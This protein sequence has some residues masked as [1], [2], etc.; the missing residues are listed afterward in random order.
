MYLLAVFWHYKTV[1]AAGCELIHETVKNF[2]SKISQYSYGIMFSL[3][4]L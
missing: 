1:L 2:I 4:L 3:L